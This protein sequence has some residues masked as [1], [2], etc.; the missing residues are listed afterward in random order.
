MWC[1]ASS[2]R[3]VTS[4]RS[5]LHCGKFWAWRVSSR[6]RVW[7]TSKSSIT[8]GST[9][10]HFPPPPSIH[11]LHLP[12]SCWRRPPAVRR[13]STTW[14]ASAGNGM[15]LCG[16]PSA[17]FT[18]F[19]SARTWDTLRTTTHSLPQPSRSSEHLYRQWHRGSEW[20]E[21]SCFHPTLWAV[22]KLWENLL[23]WKFSAKV[24]SSELKSPSLSKFRDRIEILSTRH[25]HCWKIATLACLLFQLATPLLRCLQ[26]VSRPS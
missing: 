12:R 6:S 7:T 18:C 17:R 25:L 5:A 9:T 10:S 15:T 4:G 8:A 26:N 24:L 21:G 1:R 13:R 2:R 23:L 11:L 3:R 20:G 16:R 22:G 19:C 14:C